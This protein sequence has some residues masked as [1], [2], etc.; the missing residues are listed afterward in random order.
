MA[1]ELK[2]LCIDI[3]ALSEVRFAGVGSLQ[4]ERVG[5][6]LFWSGKPETERRLSG[7]GFMIK[8][9]IVSKLENLP[10]CHSDRIMSMRLTLNNNQNATLFS[11]YS[12]TLMSDI[13]DRTKFYNDLQ[14]LIR[15]V[16]HNDKIFI[17]GDFN[18]RV[19][20]DADA[21]QGVIGKHGVGNR[22]ESGLLLLE[23]CTELQLSITN[24]LFQQKNSLKTSWMHPRSKHWHLI[25]YILV[26]QRDV[27]DV[28]HTRVMPSAECHTDH[29]LVRCKVA[30]QFKPT[31]RKGSI[32]QK[33]FR[34]DALRS[35]TVRA[36]Y[37]SNLQAKLVDLNH[38][39]DPSTL[40]NELKTAILQ[41]SSEVL[42]YTRKKNKDWFDPENE[43]VQHLLAKKR[44]THKALLAL[45]NCPL[46][47]KAFRDVCSNLQRK[48][49][50][51]KNTWWSELSS[52]IQRYADS[53]NF[54]NFYEALKAVYGPSHKSV[55]PLRSLDGSMLLTDKTSILNRW[56]EHF[57]NLFNAKRTVCDK[58]ILS[59]PQ[60]P[61]KSDLD[62]HPT[63]EETVKAINQL[64]SGKAAGID[65]IPSELWKCGGQTLHSMLH[66]L[67]VACWDTGKIPNDLRDAV[68]I[69]LYK[70]KGDKSDCPNHRG[71]TLLSI[72][73]KILAR[74]LLNRLTPSIAENFLPETQ[75]G[76]RRN[77][78]T[79]DM[80]FVLRQIQEKCREQ[81]KGLYITF[82]DLTKAFDTVNR[83][84]LW[85]VMKRLGCPS[86]FLTMIMELHEGQ[87]GQVRLGND[88]SQPFSICN[89][90][91]QGCV[92]ASTLFSV[93]FSMMLSHAFQD[94]DDEDA[95]YIRYRLDGNLF[96]LRRLKAHTKTLQVLVREL[97]FADD[98]ALVAHTEAALQRL[99][100]CFADS[101]H[102]FGLE[103]SLNKT[104]VLYQPAPCEA[105]HPPH[106]SINKT[107]LNAVQYFKYLG[108]II[109]SDAKFEKEID[110]RLS[111]ANRAFGRLHKR[112]WRNKEL[113]QET[114]INLYRA[115]VLSTLL[116]GSESWVTY[117]HH[118]R[119]LERFHQRCLR[120]ILQLKW[121]DYVS[122]IT[123]LERSKQTSIEALLLKRRLRW[124]GHVSRMNNNR[125]PKMVLFGEL[126]E[127]H[128]NIGLPLKR[129]KDQLK[130]S[131][132]N[133][134]VPQEA[135]TELASDRASWR[136][137]VH[138]AA[139]QFEKN[140][141]ALAAE[142][143]YKRNNPA[144][145]TEP[146]LHC[147]KCGRACF[148]RIGLFSHQ[149]A[150]VKD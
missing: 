112:V 138:H 44:S 98:A 51:I 95:V 32:R 133:I 3:A 118:I 78:G 48:L 100:S 21:W 42:G 40:W 49:R 101:A 75:C 68:I 148:S 15:K 54:R 57:Q 61:I 38:L 67:L 71:I 80:V 126:I 2:R 5:Y 58:A 106:V 84:A 115:V 28:L 82:V 124:A 90:V 99:V 147:V 24:T 69:T 12:P 26:R 97:L 16:P 50:E 22:N 92:L 137:T 23:F 103:V 76:F 129:F 93:F 136:A 59:I 121:W 73:G 17:L 10:A 139:S 110:H 39:V 8:N 85:Q 20:R 102:L 55:S 117:S 9:S 30:L 149:R 77:R 45:P 107:E 62:L 35:E 72:A 86:K 130:C 96:N 27:R 140:R 14:N 94:L 105:H 122:D 66:K 56:S 116:Y 111:A 47:R 141:R 46:K 125:L 29:R 134:D 63:L 74:I 37:Q 19:G 145:N 18:A 114:K 31:V 25:D 52:E 7:V 64:K 33:K 36:E 34:L 4:E 109:S 144:T 120:T 132:S 142:K 127:G 6:T 108:S 143:S 70:N 104:E 60:S 89:G 135:W 43:E 91:K 88:L 79:T 53:G 113:R 81:N 131:L 41:T 13:G 119:I 87:M 146:S 150:C 123:V 1:L 83:K 128:R 65:G 11:V